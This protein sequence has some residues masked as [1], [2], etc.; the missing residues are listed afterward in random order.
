[1]TLVLADLLASPKTFSAVGPR[2][3][4]NRLIHQQLAEILRDDGDFEYPS[5]YTALN[6]IQT[7]TA[8]T[9]GVDGGTYTLTF[10]FRSGE[11]FTTAAIAY[12]A[13]AATIKTA[14][15]TAATL[16]GIVGWTNND[17]AVTGGPLSTTTATFT[18]SGTSVASN[19]HGQTTING[20]ALTVGGN[21][22]GAAG[23]AATSQN[24]QTARKAWAALNVLGLVT[25]APPAQGVDPTGI[26]TCP[27]GGFP[28]GLSPTTVKALVTEAAIEDLNQGTATAL[29]AALHL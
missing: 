16:A 17:I 6:E 11:T 22:G 1:L 3:G 8:H 27:R 24:G 21:P 7:I 9:G 25:S 14:I 28:H 4:D 23:T 12:D 5:G 26:T 2:V 18:F 13:N 10:N 19:N 20:A 15:N 29:L